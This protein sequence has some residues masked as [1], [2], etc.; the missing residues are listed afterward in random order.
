MYHVTHL[1]QRAIWLDRGRI[2]MMGE[3]RQIV[4]AYEDWSRER[5]KKEKKEEPASSPDPNLYQ[6]RLLSPPEVQLKVFDPLEVEAVYRG[7]PE[8]REFC[9]GFALIRNDEVT[10]F[11]SSTQYHGLKVPG[12]EG[13]FRL[14]FPRLPLLSGSYRLVLVLADV[15]GNLVLATDTCKITVEKEHLLFG[16]TFLEHQWEI[17]S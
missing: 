6:I 8:D 11:A 4:Q 7:A 5:A 3:A 13:R 9:L 15:S 12:P 17:S 1:C 2:R 10:V 16:T 14:S